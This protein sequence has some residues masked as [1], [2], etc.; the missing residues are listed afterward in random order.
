VRRVIWGYDTV[1][2]LYDHSSCIHVLGDIQK[3]FMILMARDDP[4]SLDEDVP[5]DLILQNPNSLL[6]QSDHGIHCDFFT[7]EQKDSGKSVRRLYPDIVISYIDEVSKCNK[8]I[9]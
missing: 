1:E 7:E 3:P 9:E 2:K 6:I 4:V 8:S 5:T